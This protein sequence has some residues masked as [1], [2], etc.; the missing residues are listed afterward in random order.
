MLERCRFTCVSVRCSW[1]ALYSSLAVEAEEE[2]HEDEDDDENDD[3]VEDS[4]DDFS[5]ANDMTL[6]R[7]RTTP[8]TRTGSRGT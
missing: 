4:G 5:A 7:L 2:E 1:G 8:S 3:V 6:E